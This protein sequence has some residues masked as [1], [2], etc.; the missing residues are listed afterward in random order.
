MS[1][2]NKE[3]LFGEEEMGKE[4]R[5]KNPEGFVSSV[6]DV[7]EEDS[8][9]F[10]KPLEHTGTVKSKSKVKP[11]ILSF[12]ALVLVAAIIAATVIFWPVKEEEEPE[13]MG[14]TLIQMMD[15]T[16]FY[17][18]TEYDETEE[19]DGTI[20]KIP[21]VG[22]DNVLVDRVVLRRGEYN[23]E[24]VLD[25]YEKETE[26]VDG[27]KVTELKK[28]W[29]LKH[30]D[31]SL[32]SYATIDNAV[33]S[34]MEQ[35]YTKVIS[36]NKKDGK[37]YGFDDP[38]YQVDFY[39]PGSD[40]V[41][42]S[43]II[44]GKSPADDGRYITSSLDDKVY[45]A[46]MVDLYHYEKT[47][48]DFVNSES[49]PSIGADEDYNSAYFTDGQLI[50]CERLE[51]WG[52]VPGEHYNIVT[53]TVDHDTIFNSYHIIE[54]VN[55][56]ADDDSMGNI[57]SLFSYG[58]TA[59]GCYSYSTTEEELKKFGLDDPDFG[60][61]IY[62][63]DVESSFVATKQADGNYAVYYAANKTIM[64]VLPESL[65]P[66]SYTPKDIYNELLFIESISAASA[67]TIESGEE[68]LRF[69]ISTKYDSESNDDVIS[70][71]KYNGKALE[72][73]NFQNY[74]SYI[75]KIAAQSY[76]TVDTK[77][78]KPATVF[79]V[80]HKN[81]SDPTVIKYFKIND[82]RYQVEVDGVKMGLI[83]SSEHS[84]IL[85]YAKNV[86]NDKT[87]NSRG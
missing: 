84:R 10:S 68:K 70:G 22:T 12:V 81:G 85:K 77:D 8:T 86:A 75:I 17:N 37:D 67:I 13:A 28:E 7:S 45:F 71:V 16:L 62:V 65:I 40:K 78:M 14:V 31:R 60:V 64:K 83:S 20:T 56:P 53:K 29:A 48:L 1:S 34:F 87:Y 30:V 74:Y 39:K 27:N 42:V 44:G 23:L 49:I 46:R 43:L 58:I 59:N 3:N 63:N 79:T 73:I 55:R 11:I 33:Q 41:Y 19:A 66:A 76:E 38:A 15:D 47:D 69:D 26:D 32:T 24:F 82:A 25:E 80:E 2:E 4:K 35:G 61:K 5:V 18:V 9:I 57:V 36:D 72:T 21:V 50:S 52:K 6:Y 51:I 54:P